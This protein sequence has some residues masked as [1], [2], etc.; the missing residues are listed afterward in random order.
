MEHALDQEML[1]SL[2]EQEEKGKPRKGGGAAQISIS[3]SLS[4]ITALTPERRRS[5]EKGIEGRAKDEGRRERDFLSTSLAL[6][7]GQASSFCA[8]CY[9]RRDN[10]LSKLLPLS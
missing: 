6:S 1:K 4:F 3:G 5:G 7:L 9:S 10:P 8:F 2:D